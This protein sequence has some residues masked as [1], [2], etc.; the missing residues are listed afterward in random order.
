MSP[1]NQEPQDV[2]CGRDSDQGVWTLPADI[3]ELEPLSPVMA[4][5][6]LPDQTLDTSVLAELRALGEGSEQ[7]F[8]VEL[9]DLFLHDAPARRAGIAR[10]VE[11]HDARALVQVSHQF[12]GSSGNLGAYRL[13]TLCERLE[14]AG[15]ENRLEDSAALFSALEEELA[16]VTVLLEG[17]RF[18]L[19]G[20]SPQARACDDSA[21]S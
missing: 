9:I 11:E 20:K 2:A 1:A 4:S 18:G 15:K 10:A 17:E 3:D 14:M 13:A 16:R 6:S 21:V 19:G 8:V 12:R 5:Q 7:N